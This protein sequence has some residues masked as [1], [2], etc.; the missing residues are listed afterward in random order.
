MN[1]N[2]ILSLYEDYLVVELGMA[3][4]SVSTYL[5]ECRALVERLTELGLSLETVTG[6]E[7]SEYLIRRRTEGID[8]L[9]VSKALSSFRSLFRYLKLEKYRTDDPTEL[10]ETPRTRRK[11]PGVL[12]PEEV[13]RV[14]D[15]VDLDDPV[16]LRDRALFELIYSCGLRVSEAVELPLGRLFLEEGLVRITGKGDKQRLVPLGAEAKRWI[17]AYLQY[18]RPA[19]A[20]RPGSC[21]KVFLSRRGTGISRKGIWKRFKQTAAAAGVEA[22]VHTLRHSFATHLL[23]GG[24]DL[25]AVQELLGHA[26]IGTTQIYTHVDQD[27]LAAAHRKFHPRG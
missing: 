19:L 17:S 15:T 11:I 22:K 24:A 21:D 18:G 5:T 3:P 26:D 4:Q 23:Q 13:D 14:L 6:D 9:T 25:R 12:S 20:G 7:L 27:D 16:G 10:L 2:T 8:A 1:P